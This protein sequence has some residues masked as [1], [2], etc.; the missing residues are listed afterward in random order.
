ME[1]YPS[2]WL[3]AID[4]S[5]VTAS[6]CHNG[7]HTG[8]TIN[9]TYTDQQSLVIATDQS[10]STSIE[11]SQIPDSEEPNNAALVVP[12]HWVSGDGKIIPHNSKIIENLCHQLKL[13]A[14]GFF[15]SDEAIV[16]SNNKEDGF[17]SSFVL[18]NIDN[19]N[20]SISLVYLGK[21]KHRIRKTDES[22][23]G[24]ALVEGLLNQLNSSSAL[25]PQIILYGLVD[26][27]L[28]DEFKNYAWLNKNV[29]TFLHFPDVKLYSSRDLAK[30]YFAAITKQISPDN[31]ETE[32]SAIDVSPEQKSTLE[33]TDMAEFGF[34]DSEIIE[35]KIPTVGSDIPIIDAKNVDI[36]N[37]EI[38]E[39]RSIA[40]NIKI[41][42]FTFKLNIFYFIPLLLIPL[43]II[44]ILYFSSAIRSRLRDVIAM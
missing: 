44:S 20:L 1:K 11:K 6:L 29:E 32:K 16:E 35:E 36:E 28:L 2:F 19:N 3:I 10:F 5:C 21:V 34:S 7:I 37:M 23:P 15:T 40:K 14:L 24:P 31:P 30:M 8:S 43:I 4:D 22:H 17:P 12:A 25:Q 18:V 13:K 27:S 38:F 39:T 42:K 33:K 26:D 9:W 41:P